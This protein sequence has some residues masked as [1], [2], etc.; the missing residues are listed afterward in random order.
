MG[1]T[2]E[3][4][5]YLV[6]S[7]FI[8]VN[9][10]YADVSITVDN[11]YKYFK[12]DGL[13]NHATGP[14]P[15]PGNPNSIMAQN[16]AY[17]VS[18]SP[19]LTD[20]AQYFGHDMLFGI[21]INGVVFDPPTIEYYNN[22]TNWNYEALSGKI[23]L[24][25]DY[26]NAHVQ[27]NGAYHYHGLPI[28]LL[29]TLSADQLLSPIGYAADGF[30]IYAAYGQS[31]AKIKSSYRLKSGTRYGGPGGRYDGTFLQD[32]EYVAGLG[33]LDECNGVVAETPDTKKK[34]Y[35]YYVT[36]AF[37][38]VPRCFKGVSD[39]SFKKRGGMGMKRGRP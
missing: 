11:K 2:V 27:P 19:K 1:M 21:A 31:K 14:F 37:P 38:F 3:R 15:C 17:K 29:Q 22:D 34:V 23:N 32:Y 33:N 13:P 4:N 7:L 28:G 18:A 25:I 35:H 20:S 10:A 36:E 5:F 9:L 24:G 39:D 26:S 16:K 6:I 8:V 12:T 30:A